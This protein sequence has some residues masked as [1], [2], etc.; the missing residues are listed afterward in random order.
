M[1]NGT[2]RT[3]LGLEVVAAVLGRLDGVVLSKFLQH[4]ALA[5]NGAHPSILSRV[6]SVGRSRTGSLALAAAFA[7]LFE[8]STSADT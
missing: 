1:R 4:S 2:V 5:S 3:A 8:S 7:L 6:A